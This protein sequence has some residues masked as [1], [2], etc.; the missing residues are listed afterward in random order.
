MT[1]TWRP[2]GKNVRH[3]ERFVE[4]YSR[5]GGTLE[6][7]D[8]LE[9]GCGAGIDALLIAMHPVR[10][11]VGIDMEL[12]LFDAGE[13]GERTRRLTREVLAALVLSDDVDAVL[14]Q[15]PVRLMTMD[16]T[17]MSFPDHSFDLLWS[18]AAME[19]IVPSEPPWRKWR[20][21]SGPEG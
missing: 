2:P 1:I 19:H 5:L 7:A 15:R 10:S 20:A 18:R 12:P 13:K 16:A 17:R 21:S 8:V 9:V 3:S 4:E 14:R 6:D 11:V